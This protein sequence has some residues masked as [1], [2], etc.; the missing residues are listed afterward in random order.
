MS[1]ETK[2]KEYLEKH[3]SHFKSR[4]KTSDN[5]IDDLKADIFKQALNR[6]QSEGWDKTYEWV[7]NQ[8]EKLSGG[9]TKLSRNLIGGYK[10]VKDKMWSLARK[11][12]KG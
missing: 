4:Y 11:E 3:I 9:L 2:F 10:Q 12:N 7:K 6:F 8:Y 5:I 1:K